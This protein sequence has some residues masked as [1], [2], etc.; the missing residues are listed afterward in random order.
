MASNTF[1]FNLSISSIALQSSSLYLS[2]LLSSLLCLVKIQRLFSLL[3]NSFS[4]SL[5]SKSIII[6]L[7]VNCDSSTI[8]GSSAKSI[9]ICLLIH[10]W[11]PERPSL[12]F[13]FSAVLNKILYLESKYTPARKYVFLKSFSFC[14]FMEDRIPNT[15]YPPNS[16]IHFSSLH[17][18][19]INIP[20]VRSAA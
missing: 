1:T 9:S 6:I 5:F 14:Y 16:S 11:M 7:Q 12:A 15:I 3:S 10:R 4:K 19:F 20:G 13:S 8:A 2:I 18:F 17:H